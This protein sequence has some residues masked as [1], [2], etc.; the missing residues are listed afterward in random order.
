[1]AKLGRIFWNNN[2]FINLFFLLISE[3]TEIQ[4]KLPKSN[5]ITSLPWFV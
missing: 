2:D 5:Y 3:S 4:Y 1:M